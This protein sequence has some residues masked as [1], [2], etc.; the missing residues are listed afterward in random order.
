LNESGKVVFLEFDGG[1]VAYDV[2]GSVSQR[3]FY[4]DT[5]GPAGRSALE[6]ALYV[7]YGR[8]GKVLEVHYSRGEADQ[9]RVRTGYYDWA[10]NKAGK[11]I[12]SPEKWK[13]ALPWAQFNQLHI[14]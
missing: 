8:N 7:T 4:W 10:W 14:P 2:N 11:L 13:E 12:K 5:K 6:N 9:E 3:I 1:T